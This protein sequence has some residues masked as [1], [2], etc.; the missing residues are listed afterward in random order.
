MKIKK[1]DVEVGFIEPE[2][3]EELEANFSVF[4]LL[5]LNLSTNKEKKRKK[6]YFF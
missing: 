5:H 2:S 3:R 1:R 6:N 4:P